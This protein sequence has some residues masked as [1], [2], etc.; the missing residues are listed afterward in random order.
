[1]KRPFQLPI[2]ERFAAF[3]GEGCHMGL[4][5]FFIRTYGCPVKC[6][7]CDSAGTWHKDFAPKKSLLVDVPDLVKEAKEANHVFVVLTGGE[8]CIHREGVQ[9]LS[10]SL[11]IAKIALHV[12][13]CGAFPLPPSWFDWITVSP[14]RDALPK[15][16]M[17]LAANELKIIVDNVGA[18]EEWMSFINGT[19][20]KVPVWLHPEWSMRNDPSIL[21]YIS[22]S[23]KLRGG[24]FRAGYQLH[25][26]YNVDKLDKRSAPLVPLGGNPKKGF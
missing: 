5:A 26:L 14:K 1:M 8:P 18:I 10:E 3:Q 12:E 6:K 23:V 4:S 9:A 24:R 11:S 25:K 21:N 7:F 16:E 2:H 15:D 22:E 20:P 19:L 17:L 13:T